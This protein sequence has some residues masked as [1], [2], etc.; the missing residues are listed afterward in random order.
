MLSDKSSRRL[1]RQARGQEARAG[2]ADSQ[3]GD[4]S[5][6]TRWSR[7]PVDVAVGLIVIL[8]GQGVSMARWS[9]AAQACPG[10]QFRDGTCQT[11]ADPP[12]PADPPR[13]ALVLCHEGARDLTTEA[14]IELFHSTCPSGW[15]ATAHLESS[16]T[17]RCSV[18]ATVAGS[19]TLSCSAGSVAG[20]NNQDCR[21]VCLRC[22]YP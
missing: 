7:I 6:R 15:N 22:E 1:S 12:P 9:S 17:Q 4:H 2:G 11:T 13:V 18:T 8:I 10:V 20:F 21:G 19:S 14:C 3:S 5:I 16:L